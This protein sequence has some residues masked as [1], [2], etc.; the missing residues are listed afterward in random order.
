MGPLQWA[1]TPERKQNPLYPDQSL[2]T[3]P[4]GQTWHHAENCVWVGLN[5]VLVFIIASLGVELGQMPNPPKIPQV[6]GAVKF[7]Y[8]TW[9][10]SPSPI[11]LVLGSSANP[12][13]GLTKR[14]SI[15]ASEPKR[16]LYHPPVERTYILA[17]F[18]FSCGKG[19][20]VPLRLHKTLQ[21]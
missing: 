18:T 14:A 15:F 11:L 16:D 7:W 20:C 2:R 4:L 9:W 3:E 1:P 8:Y 12:R 5:Q 6:P 13:P 21:L 19:L 17:R 10:L